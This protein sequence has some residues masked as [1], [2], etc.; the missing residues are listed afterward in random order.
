MSG[1]TFLTPLAALAGVAA[2]VPL[3]ALAARERRAARLR[4]ALGLAHPPWSARI[5]RALAV[6]TVVGLLAAAAAQPVVRTSRAA[7]LRR[8]AQAF[9]V[10]DVSRS[11][12]AAR[13]AHAPTRLARAVGVA[14]RLRTQLPDVPAGI[15]TLT[16]RLLPNLFPTGDAGGFARVAERSLAID[17][18]PP[19]QVRKRS[20]DFGALNQLVLGD[21][22]GAET[23]GAKTF[24]APTRHR[25]VVL[26]T[27]GESGAFDVGST[28]RSLREAR[29][30]LIVVRFWHADE[31]I[32]A[33][34]RADETGY[35]PDPTATAWADK[36]GPAVSGFAPFTERDLAGAGAAARKL[37]GHGPTGPASRAVRERPLSS[38]V[39]AA[40]GLPLALLLLGRGFRLR[41]R[42]T[43]W[44]RGRARRPTVGAEAGARARG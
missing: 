9:F 7:V 31:R 39:A 16:D 35:R 6:V 5:A 11:M 38:Y 34:S 28:A 23:F 22:F 33:G 37:L 44:R 19:A 30:D 26:L 2:L 10:V 21:Y 14:E 41:W 36:L 8:D 12:E 13:G 1:L 32:Y 4:R 18:P 20:T 40:A 43:T 25:L 29:I 15:A 27:D 24:G 3:A 17:Q 42:P